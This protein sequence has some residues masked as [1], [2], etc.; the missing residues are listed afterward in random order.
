MIEGCILK[1]IFNRKGIIFFVGVNSGLLSAGVLPLLTAFGLLAGG[2][3]L[4]LGTESERVG[5]HQPSRIKPS[6]P[7]NCKQ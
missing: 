2:A 4:V 7:V 1:G 3:A 6:S 5:G